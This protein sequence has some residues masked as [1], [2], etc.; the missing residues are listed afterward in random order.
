MFLLCAPALPCRHPY[1]RTPWLHGARVAALRGTLPRPFQRSTYPAIDRPKTRFCLLR[2]KRQHFTP[3]ADT[4]PALLFTSRFDSTRAKPWSPAPRADRDETSNRVH[5]LC[6]R[7]GRVRHKAENTDRS[8]PLTLSRHTS[9]D[10]P[11]SPS[12]THW[13]SPAENTSRRHTLPSL[14][15]AALPFTSRQPAGPAHLQLSRHAIPARWL[16]GRQQKDP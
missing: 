14:V 12:P 16:S 2:A 11:V 8:T 4:Q 9:T 10:G 13:P 6:P 5:T 1:S 7:P 3:A 15:L